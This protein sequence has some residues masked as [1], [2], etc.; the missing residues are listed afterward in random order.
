M[1]ECCDAR[2]NTDNCASVTLPGYV[3]CIPKVKICTK[4]SRKR[5]VAYVCGPSA[6]RVAELSRT[7]SEAD[8]IRL[9][10]LERGTLCM[11]K[12]SGQ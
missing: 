4:L 8:S 2:A 7:L 5:A 11:G 6:K 3:Q 1:S 10:I 9:F 12:M